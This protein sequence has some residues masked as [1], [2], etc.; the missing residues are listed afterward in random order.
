MLGLKADT[1]E[2][3]VESL[4]SAVTALIREI[5]LDPNFQACDIPEEDW[6][7]KLEKIA[8]LAYEDQCSPANPRLPMVADMIE[9]LKKAYKGN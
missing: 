3:G 2:E 7:S 9:I 4:A 6:N 1:P 5:G 8:G